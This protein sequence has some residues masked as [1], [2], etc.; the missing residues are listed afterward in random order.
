MAKGHSHSGE[1]GSG[2]RPRCR[3]PAAPRGRNAPRLRG[4]GWVLD[5]VLRLA[6]DRAD[7]A[8]LPRKAGQDPGLLRLESVTLGVEQPLPG[9]LLGHDLLGC[10]RPDCSLVRHLEEK[11]IGELLGVFEDA[12]SVIPQDIALGPQLVDQSP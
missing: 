5:A 2:R 7:D 8:G 6:V 10:Q 11:Q 3:S 9:A 4:L 1:D 12:H